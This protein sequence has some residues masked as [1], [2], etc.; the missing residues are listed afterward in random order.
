MGGGESLDAEAIACVWRMLEREG[1][2]REE[3]QGL[4]TIST[5]GKVGCQAG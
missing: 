4:S 2:G 5:Q 1:Q 3:E